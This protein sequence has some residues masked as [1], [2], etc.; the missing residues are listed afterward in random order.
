MDGAP[1]DRCN[2]GSVFVD[3]DLVFVSVKLGKGNVWQSV[4]VIAC[5]ISACDWISA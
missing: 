3:F 4:K 2:P 5:K 1:V